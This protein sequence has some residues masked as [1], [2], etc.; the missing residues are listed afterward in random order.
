MNLPN[1]M[2][3]KDYLALL[4]YSDSEKAFIGEV[5]GIKSIPKFSARSVAELEAA[6][7]QSVEQYLTHCQDTGIQP[8]ISYRGTFNIRTTPETHRALAL[9]AWTQGESLNVIVDRAFNE[10]LE[11]HFSKDVLEFCKEQENTLK[12]PH[13]EV[14]P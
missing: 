3:Y 13:A 5:F 10:Y 8:K 12:N 1:T 11:R 7:H 2:R 4:E 14:K 9:Y 6:F